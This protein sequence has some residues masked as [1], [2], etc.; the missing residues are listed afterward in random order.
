MLG[1]R[2]ACVAYFARFEGCAAVL[3]G[4]WMGDKDMK[5]L[6]GNL[7][8][9]VKR[10]VCGVGTSVKRFVK[11]SRAVSTVEYA[12][13]VVAV[14]AIVGGAAL[15]LGGAFKELFDDLG[16]EMTDGITDTADKAGQGVATTT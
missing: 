2:A 12:L 13:I 8:G 3:I 5:T 15:I 4:K 9:G 10:A 1:A 6:V 14:I 16:D 11:E 7:W